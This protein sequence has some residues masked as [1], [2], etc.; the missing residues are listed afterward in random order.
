MI[1]SIE[2]KNQQFDNDSV[3][4]MIKSDLKLDNSENFD[5]YGVKVFFKDGSFVEGL[6][7]QE[8]FYEYKKFWVTFVHFQKLKESMKV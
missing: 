2:G 7:S 8:M 6:L 1:L 4:F 3:L 5:F